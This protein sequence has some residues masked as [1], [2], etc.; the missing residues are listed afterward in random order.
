[1]RADAQVYAIHVKESHEI[2]W[3]DPS[4]ANL[5]RETGIVVDKKSVLAHTRV[6][7]DVELM[8]N[9]VECFIRRYDLQ[10]GDRDFFKEVVVES[11]EE[12]G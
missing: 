7:I 2:K 11:V 12:T 3:I 9:E 6:G 4:F 5:V 10:T 8:V 1:M